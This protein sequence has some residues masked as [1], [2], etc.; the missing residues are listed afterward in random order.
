MMRVLIAMSVL[1]LIA[2]PVRAQGKK[3]KKTP[4][5]EMG[6]QATG[7]NGAVCAGGSEA[8]AAGLT[9]LQK[10]GNAIDSAAATILALTVTDSTRVCFGGEAPIMVYDVKRNVVELLCGL[11]AAP[12]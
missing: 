1:V 12:K 3:I 10:G 4:S 2:G 9:T 6:F 11:G 8:V 5:P 7:K